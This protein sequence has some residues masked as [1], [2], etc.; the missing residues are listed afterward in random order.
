VLEIS[1]SRIPGAAPNGQKEGKENKKPSPNRKSRQ[2]DLPCLSMFKKK[3]KSE[4]AKTNRT[5]E[6]EFGEF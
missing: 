3:R 6:L 4:K 2:Q 5:A 1:K